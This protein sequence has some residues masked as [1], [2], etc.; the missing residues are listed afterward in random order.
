MFVCHISTQYVS[1]KVNNQQSKLLEFLTK[2]IHLLRMLSSDHNFIR[3][4]IN[5]YESCHSLTY[6]KHLSR[7]Y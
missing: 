2:T 6:N 1:C 7:F 4:F 3:H 5:V